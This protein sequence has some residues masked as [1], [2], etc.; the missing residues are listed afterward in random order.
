MKVI[1]VIATFA[2]VVT[3][4]CVGKLSI[5]GYFAVGFSVAGIIYVL[6]FGLANSRGAAL[7]VIGT[8]VLFFGVVSWGM[9][10][11]QYDLRAPQEIGFM[12]LTAENAPWTYDLSSNELTDEAKSVRANCLT[13]QSRIFS[14]AAFS[15]ASTVYLPWY[16]TSFSWL[17]E[18]QP[19]LTCID[20][21][22][23]LASKAP[24]L[25]T[26]MLLKPSIAKAFGQLHR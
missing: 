20:E 13:E 10:L 12:L 2:V 22:F 24:A 15:G 23:A 19:K 11:L 25:K 6:V 14:S 5:P 26:V 1:L 7:S 8:L 9:A 3:V 16:T 21:A 17:W 18:P 4:F